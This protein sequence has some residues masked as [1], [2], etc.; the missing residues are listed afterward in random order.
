[1]SHSRTL[2]KKTFI[3][4]AVAAVI[5][6]VIAS[7]VFI[8]A[9]AVFPGIFVKKLLPGHL[10]FGILGRIDSRRRR[11]R[12]IFNIRITGDGDWNKIKFAA[13]GNRRFFFITCRFLMFKLLRGN[14]NWGCRKRW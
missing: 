1:M 4:F 8:V 5:I 6:V 13:L 14:G 11:S 10:G 9:V 2:N 7:I 12:N 3:I